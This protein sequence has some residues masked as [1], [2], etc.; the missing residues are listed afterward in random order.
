MTQGS[1]FECTKAGCSQHGQRHRAHSA[2]LAIGGDGIDPHY[3]VGK[4]VS[5]AKEQGGVSGGND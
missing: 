5:T 2:G 1:L 4:G 3:S